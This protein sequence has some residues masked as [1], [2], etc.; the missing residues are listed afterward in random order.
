M[1]KRQT[2]IFTAIILLSCSYRDNDIFLSP[3]FVNLKGKET[4]TIIKNS[5]TDTLRLRGEF[6]NGLP[7]V[8]NAFKLSI[9]PNELDT[10]KFH[11]TY[12]DFI[13][14]Y[15]TNYFRLFNSPGKTLYCDIVSLTSKTTNI[16]FRGEL[17]DINNYY[18]AYHN[19]MGTAH[20]QNRP[21]FIMGDI[22]KDFNKFPSIA[23]SITQLSLGFLKKYERQL[24]NWF[25]KHE[26]WRLKYNSGFL[27]HNVLFSK[28]FYSGKKINVSE[29]FYSYEKELP[30][31]NKEMVLNGE[32]IWYLRSFVD[33]KAIALK[34]KNKKADKMLE[35]F[36][37]DSLFKES[38]S[39]DIFKMD[40]LS[41]IYHAGQKRKYDSLLN[42]TVFND[43]NKKR[44][45]DS[46]VNVEYGLPTVGTIVP[47]LSLTNLN[48]EKVSFSNFKGNYII[49]NFWATW[50]GPCIAEFPNE[51]KLYLENKDK[52]LTVINIC[53][54]S[55]IEQWK[56]VSKKKEI[57]TI[58]VFTDKDEYT[59]ISNRFGISALPKS[60]LLDKNLFVVDN[61]YKRASQLTKE[62][63]NKITKK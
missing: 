34:S 9:P 11:F 57:K 27:I 25:K 38:V 18:L 14:V 7:Y 42:T 60:I 1:I 54:D 16:D 58:N 17:A 52:G 28:Q 56:N 46:L 61:N 45:L 21:Y 43:N 53:L 33:N 48:G 26:E 50:C 49:V 41:G 32:Y 59:Y 12:P 19:T 55:E 23:D 51:N 35:F 62:D 63:I 13:Y 40:K 10:L 47:N 22:I 6:F 3:D 8:A 24:P 39:A 31:E 30:I 44:I 15:E 20:E 29:K 4:L 2:I 5:T 36:V 37:V